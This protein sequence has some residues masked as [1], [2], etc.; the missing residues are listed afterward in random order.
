MFISIDEAL[1]T[2]ESG[3]FFNMFI[4]FK[5]I[6]C[7]VTEKCKKIFTNLHKSIFKLHDIILKWIKKNNCWFYI[8][9]FKLQQNIISKKYKSNKEYCYFLGE[10]KTDF[11]SS[12]CDQNPC[13]D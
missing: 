4:K 13:L 10:R 8:N 1:D 7:T 9:I 11:C 3:S 12:L 6:V 2:I 5:E